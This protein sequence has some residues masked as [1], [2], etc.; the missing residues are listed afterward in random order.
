MT[1]LKRFHK[2]IFALI[3]SATL[4][5]VPDLMALEKPG[6]PHKK[7]AVSKNEK[8]FHKVAD[9]A[10]QAMVQRAEEL[11]IQGVAVI[12]Y[13]EGDA[14]K[15][16]ISKMA[17]VGSLKKEP[18]GNNKGSNLL[19][20]VYAKAAEMADTLQNSGSGIRPPMTGELG[21]KGGLVTKGKT[22]YLIA[23]FSGG[24]S[25]EDLQVSQTGLDILAGKL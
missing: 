15:A 22:G 21:W 20:I 1:T 19:G 8:A 9:K 13:A 23:A 3:L 16:W 25:E 5:S 10:L 2:R 7:Q 4:V 12:A 17:V 18:S 24:R 14:I 6:K 11:K